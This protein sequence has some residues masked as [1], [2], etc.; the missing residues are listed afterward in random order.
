MRP[1][2]LAAAFLAALSPCALAPNANA[3]PDN[4]VLFDLTDMRLKCVLFG[5]CFPD[6]SRD[7]AANPLPPGTPQSI[8][9]ASGYSYHLD[10][11]VHTT[12]LA[13]SFIPDGATL[14][15]MMDILQAG[16][17]RMLSGYSRNP[18][19]GLPDPKNPVYLQTFTGNVIGLDLGITLEASISN[20][21]V[22]RFEIRDINI[23]LGILFGEAR[24]TQGSCLIETW[25]P[26]PRQETEWHFDGSLGEV[27]G[28]SRLRYLDDPAFGTILGGIGNETD[29][30]P[31]APT[32]VTQAQSSFATTT[33]LG[34]PGPG[35][36]EDMVYV[37]SPARN[38]NDSNPDLY[39]GIGLALYPRTQPAF[40]GKYCGQWTL[41]YDL[42]IPG[43]SWTGHEWPS[44]S[45]TAP[46]T[47]AAARAASSATPAR[48]PAR[49][50][51]TPSRATTS[52]R[53]RSPQTGGCGS[54]WSPTSCRP[55]SPASTSMASS[56]A[57]PTPTGSTTRPTRPIPN[58]ATSN[59]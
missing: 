36:Q 17:S 32:G 43:E 12:G 57:R 10:G 31:N 50:A 55:T 27:A 28:P 21:G 49:S 39:R 35:G 23:P 20:Q 30:N 5:E 41:I 42:Y 15:E 44:R 14:G 3:Q 6:Q 37:T 29:P 18:S 7:S 34:I 47:T 4:D 53:T 13:S 59:R 33:S 16:Q 19:G 46:R 9:P 45:S 54:P 8:V 51:S 48:A 52:R 22:G 26:S 2:S 38:L 24:I 25:N 56:S 1:R 11:V 40:P 58:T